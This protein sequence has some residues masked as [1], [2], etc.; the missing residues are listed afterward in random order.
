M[1]F[2]FD[3]AI[4]GEQTMNSRLS[5]IIVLGLCVTAFLASPL[6][7]G[8]FSI[9][10]VIATVD[11][12]DDKGNASSLLGFAGPGKS[13]KNVET[14]IIVQINRS[15]VVNLFLK[16]KHFKNR[17]LPIV[18]PQTKETLTTTSDLLTVERRRI[19]GTGLLLWQGTQI[20]VYD[21]R[22][23]VLEPETPAN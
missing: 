23:P 15:I 10:S 7:A 9:R 4:F 20:C 11:G 2:G 6:V 13:Y 16:A 8:V 22:Y 19:F 14:G 1:F 17:G 3:G 18:D 5:R 21:P 12:V